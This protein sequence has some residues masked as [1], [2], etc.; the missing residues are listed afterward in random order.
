MSLEQFEDFLCPY[1]SQPNS[2]NVDLS[3]GHSQT[4]VTDCEVCCAP[5]VVSVKLR[6]SDILSIDV[7]PENE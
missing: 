1:C 6:G 2:V 4:F 3:G 5:I 7:R